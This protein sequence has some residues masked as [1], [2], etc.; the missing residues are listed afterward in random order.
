MLK[1]TITKINRYSKKRVSALSVMLASTMGFLVPMAYADGDLAMV[2]N[3]DDDVIRKFVLR[4]DL[5]AKFAE[6]NKALGGGAN[7]SDGPVKNVRLTGKLK[8]PYIFKLQK[9]VEGE[10]RVD[11]VFDSKSEAKKFCDDLNDLTSNKS[12][13]TS[14]VILRSFWTEIIAVGYWV[15]YGKGSYQAADGGSTPVPKYIFCANPWPNWPLNPLWTDEDDSG[16]IAS[17]GVRASKDHVRGYYD[18]TCVNPENP[19]TTLWVTRAGDYIKN[20]ERAY[21]INLNHLQTLHNFN[22]SV[23]AQYCS[24][25]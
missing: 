10:G 25:K 11:V 16:A 3:D 1:N 23:G 21:R 8:R 4:P 9:E 7:V 18:V 14:A 6:L 24:G 22:E 12:Y 5:E 17:S 2:K 13:K 19:P 20:N 15:A